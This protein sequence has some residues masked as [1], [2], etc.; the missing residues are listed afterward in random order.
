MK[1]RRNIMLTPEADALVESL[2]KAYGLSVSSL[3]EQLVRRLATEQGP[4]SRRGTP[5]GRNWIL[6][7]E[8]MRT[9]EP[10]SDRMET[11]TQI[12]EDSPPHLQPPPL[13]L[14]RLNAPKKGKIK[15]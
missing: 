10:P 4:I 15:D 2:A 9:P 5:R 12:P 7:D 8:I 13:D 6:S 3:L 11:P 1:T 14:A